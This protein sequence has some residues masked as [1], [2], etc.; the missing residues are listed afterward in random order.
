VWCQDRVEFLEVWVVEDVLDLQVS[1]LSV[2]FCLDYCI[3]HSCDLTDFVVHDL[4]WDLHAVAEEWFGAFYDVQDDV[5][6]DGILNPYDEVVECHAEDV[7]VF[8]VSE[9]HDVV[10]E[11]YWLSFGFEVSDGAS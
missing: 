8:A 4:D 7:P 10:V 2:L 9:S 11:F 3:H 6:L 1:S 5:A